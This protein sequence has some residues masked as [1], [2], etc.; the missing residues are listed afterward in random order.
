MCHRVDKYLCKFVR[1]VGDILLPLQGDL[2]VCVQL[3]RALPRAD[4]HNPYRVFPPDTRMV[5]DYDLRQ[6]GRAKRRGWI[7]N[8]HRS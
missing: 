2:L 3:P 7:L 6:V 8:R 1:F 4:I 5:R